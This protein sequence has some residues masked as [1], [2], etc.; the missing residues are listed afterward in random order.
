MPHSCN[1]ERHSA[2]MSTLMP[3]LSC[4]SLRSAGFLNAYF[5]DWYAGPSAA[6]LP[7]GYNALR[8][9]YWTTYQNCPGYWEAV[10]PL[11]VLHLILPPLYWLACSIDFGAGTRALSCCMGN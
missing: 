2:E 4:V 9:M 3:L 11:K 1:L 8:I 10:S 6:R 5:S 7:F